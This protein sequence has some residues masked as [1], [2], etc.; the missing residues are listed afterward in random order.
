MT[1]GDLNIGTHGNI[2]TIKADTPIITVL[3]LFV[4]KRISALPI[5]DENERVINVYAKFDVINLA[6]ERAYTNLDI[7]ISEAL[8]HRTNVSV[9]FLICMHTFIL[10]YRYSF[11]FVYINTFAY[12]PGVF[13]EGVLSIK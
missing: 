3:N 11:M 6:R 12:T 1:L 2:T 10:I 9:N 8:S 13:N 7:P 5:V 4:E